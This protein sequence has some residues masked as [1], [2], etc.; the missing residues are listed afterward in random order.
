MSPT[1]LTVPSA[2]P[3]LTQIN[4][5]RSLSQ[6]DV[7]ETWRS[8]PDRH[9][10][11]DQPLPPT[12]CQ[13]WPL[14]SVNERHHIA[15]S[16]GQVPLWLHQRLVWP[17]HLNG[18]PLKG[19]SARLA[20]RWWADLAEVYV[21]G[22]LVQTGDIFDCWTR[23]LLTPQVVPG[24]A[25]DVALKLLSPGHDDGALVTSR[26]V[27][28]SGQATRPEPG[29]VADEL[30]VLQVYLTQF[31][32]Q[33]LPTLAQA[34]AQIDW[35]HPLDIDRFSQSLDKLRASL[36]FLSP[37]IKQRT[38]QCLGHA[39]LDL[40]WLWPVAD[41][42]VAAERTFR[43][44]LQLQQDFP[45]LT[46]T[47]SSPALF[48]WLEQHRPE[49]F[50]QIQQQVQAGR[51]A[52][53]A[54]LWV[55]PDLNLPGG[56]ALVRQILYGQR[57]CLEKFGEI[58]AIAW[59]PDT[60]GFSWQLPQLFAQGG[61]RFFA[62][63]KL[64]WNDTNPFPHQLFTWQGLDGTGITGVTLPPIGA[65]IDP[66]AM[67]RQACEWEA[68]TG[69]VQSLWLP[70]VGDHGGGPTRDMLT[71]AQRWGSSPFFP[72]LT[73]GHAQP[74]FDA[75]LQPEGLTASDALDPDALEPSGEPSTNLGLPT[76]SDELYL[77]LHRGCYTTHGDQKAFNRRGED[78]LFQAELWA[79]I[80]SLTTG[81][82]YPHKELETAWKQVLFN[83][84]HDILPG[85]SIPE[86]FADA[87]QGWQAALATA[88][89]IRQDALASLA[90]NCPLP[91]P[92]QPNAIPVVLFNALN[93]YRSEVVTLVL[94][95]GLSDGLPRGQNWQV[96]ET[97]GLVLPSQELVANLAAAIPAVEAPPTL[98]VYVPDIPPVGYRV[99]WLVPTN[100]ATA[101]ASPPKNWALENQHLRASLDPETGH[102][103][104]LMDRG[105]GQ[106]IFSGPGHQLQAFQDQGQYWD[107]WNIAPDYQEHP[108]DN[109]G[110]QSLEWIDYGAVR[111]T[112]RVVR[113]FNQSTFSQD[114]SLDIHAKQLAI[115]T[116]VDW[117]ET[118]VLVKA[119]FPLTVSAPTATY[120][121]PFGAIQRAT[122]PTT[123]QAA[124][125]W[126]VPALRWA[127]L[128]QTSPGQ[129]DRGQSKRGVSILT[130]YKHGFDATPNQLRL[131]L[132]K[133][134]LWPDPNADRGQQSFRYAIYPHALGW[135]QGKT[136]QAAHNFNIPIQ[137]WPLWPSSQANSS[138]GVPTAP[139]LVPPAAG[140]FIDLGDNTLVL[141]A[142]KC[143]EDQPNQFILRAYES[144]G[145][146]SWAEVNSPLPL[147]IL[148]PRDI[149]EQPIEAPLGRVESTG[150]YPVLPWQVVSF[151]LQR[152]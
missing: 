30:A 114:Y 64:R 12:A 67:A 24:Q 103:L 23:V 102:I 55:E 112:I 129:A 137:P 58:S 1:D 91:P 28:E 49:L 107:A 71:T 82:N 66:V 13:D 11:F 75:W 68:S 124:A 72:T 33:H 123:P 20:L 96:L 44:V 130:D 22:E 152:H 78:T 101:L 122:T 126:E 121:I 149:L 36:S 110:L 17:E 26:L 119:A 51:W 146:A 60:F 80:A 127:D 61:I 77:E 50:R 48:A 150:R 97:S 16:R 86:V 62:T 140:S 27:F 52:I 19:L 106:E 76:W 25:V 134:P 10:G 125:K 63:Q 65:D 73:F 6:Q 142:L 143:S 128:S 105:T 43:S 89:Q 45:Q 116:Q 54:G 88:S 99:I 113:T 53:D 39:H 92:P 108:L 85:S 74:L 5:L 59:L 135:Q 7:Q 95:N 31:A 47:H 41:T 84:F 133:A 2:D 14:A 111:Q 117:Q 32:P 18:Y 132:L 8:G 141:A 57:Y 104:S 35:D 37:W 40:A 38:I 90:Q 147:T 46:F 21:N 118:Q 94:P 139:E 138:V 145:T 4:R 151:A 109:F 144:T 136:V 93:W 120:E 87:N 42:W 34:T 3:I 100:Q 131:T 148:E 70:G 69:L 56:E 98:L 79:S 9:L 15:W 115:H 83:Q 81:Q 29:F